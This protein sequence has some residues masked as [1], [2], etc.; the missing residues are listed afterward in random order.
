MCLACVFQHLFLKSTVI[1]LP[2]DVWFL[3]VICE[4]SIISSRLILMFAGSSESERMLES[5]KEMFCRT[6]PKLRL[7][8]MVSFLTLRS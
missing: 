6:P 4:L 5:V 8:L 7:T 1:T 3:G 2:W